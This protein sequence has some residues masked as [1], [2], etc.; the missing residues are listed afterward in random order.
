MFQPIAKPVLSIYNN[1][2]SDDEN[3]LHTDSVRNLN[4]KFISE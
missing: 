2:K 1:S 4:S 3:I